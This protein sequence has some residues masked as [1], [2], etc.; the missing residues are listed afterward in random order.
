MR[1]TNRRYFRAHGHGNDYLVVDAGFG[2]PMT[3]ARA[4]RICD[5]NR[6]VGSDGVL[7]E[8]EGKGA[9]V[10]LRIFNPDGSEAEKSGNGLRIFAAWCFS[11]GGFDPARTLAIDTLGGRATARLLETRAECVMLSVS[12]GHVRY[13]MRDLPMLDVDGR[14]SDARWIRRALRVGDRDVEA[15]CLSVGNPHAVLLGASCDEATLHALGPL[16]ERHA[17][18]PNRTNVQL[19]EVLDRR[20]VRALVWER[21]AGPTLA[22]GSSACAVVAACAESG[23]VDVDADVEVVMPGG[24]LLVR[25]GRDGALE[26]TGPVEAIADGE[27]AEEL[28]RALSDA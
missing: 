7:V 20:R 16:V 4:R 11:R 3:A 12:M 1:P 21:G 24:S 2:L 18:F 26:Q 5:R 14:A 17:Q 19:C 6:G 8:S 27:I 22:S 23:R 15:T 10:G 25:V 28:W 13:A 9:D